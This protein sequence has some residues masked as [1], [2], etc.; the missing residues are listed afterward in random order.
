M[1]SYLSISDRYSVTTVKIINNVICI[2][3]FQSDRTPLHEAASHQRNEQV[4]E[5]LLKAG[6]DVNSVD[7]VSYYQ[8]PHSVTTDNE[9]SRTNGIKN[10]FGYSVKIDR[11]SLAS[12]LNVAIYLMKLDF[13]LGIGEKMAESL[14]LFQAV[15]NDDS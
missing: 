6:A 2:K 11:I 9:F 10:S 3:F 13:Y 14:L 4:V 15:N 5:I 1:H 8:E 7:K 12:A